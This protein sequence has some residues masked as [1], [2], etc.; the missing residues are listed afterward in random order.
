ML[1]MKFPSKCL[2]LLLLV[3]LASCSTNQIIVNNLDEREA[4]E[5]VV[6]LASKN[7]VAQ[8]VAAASSGIGAQGPS[9]L[10]NIAVAE[11]RATD[12]M[13]ILNRYGLPRRKG[14]NL[15]ELFASTGL[16]KSDRE[17]TIRYQAG[18]AEE[19][20]N[21]I[22][23]IDGV[24]D[25]DVQIS[26]PPSETTPGVAPPKTTAAVYVKHQGIAEDPNSHLETKIKRLV[27]ASINNLQYDDVT[28]VTDRSRFTDIV[29]DPNGEPIGMANQQTY[30]N[31]WNIVMTK[32]SLSRFRWIFF[33]LTI[34][35]LLFGAALGWM[36][37]KFYPQMQLPC[38]KKKKLASQNNESEPTA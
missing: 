32:S 21:T 27:S 15:L 20:K 3:F 29:L 1:I 38:F 11:N 31:I 19:L 23:K 25:A 9:N 6:F 28:V 37:Y 24:L 18:L 5:I 2:S 13:A 34:A 35:L 14:T 22:R 7:I 10:F 33:S 17:E 4:N 16:M 12:S 30:A 36:V 26:F 8:K